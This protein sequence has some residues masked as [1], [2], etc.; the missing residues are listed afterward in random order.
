M[1]DRRDRAELPELFARDDPGRVLQERRD[2]ELGAAHHESDRVDAPVARGG[3]GETGDCPARRLGVHL[4]RRAL[5]AHLHAL[6]E[7]GAGLAGEL[8]GIRVG[9]R[10]RAA[11]WHQAALSLK[12]L[13]DAQYTVVGD[14]KQLNV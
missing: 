1:L 9:Q 14:V 10:G 6:S 13:R 12:Y 7:L 4:H 11:A 5:P 8:E 2:L 3:F